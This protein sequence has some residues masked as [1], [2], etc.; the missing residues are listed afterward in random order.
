[1]IEHQFY[2]ISPDGISSTASALYGI[3]SGGSMRAR[4]PLLL[5]LAAAALIVLPGVAMG[6][7]PDAEGPVVVYVVEPGDTLWG[8]AHRLD[9]AG[10]PRPVVD[11]LLRVNDLG[12][13]LQAGQPL[14]IPAALAEGATLDTAPVGAGG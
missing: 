4:L 6:G 14:R 7:G 12:S 13:G 9:P 3:G 10:D 2:G 1:L 11:R 8:I 5:L